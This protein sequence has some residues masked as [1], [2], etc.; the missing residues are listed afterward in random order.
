MLLGFLLFSNPG[1]SS[2]QQHNQPDMFLLTEYNKNHNVE[3]WV[4]SE[5]LD[6]IR[7]YWNGQQLLTR[8]GNV[9]YAPAWFIKGLP[10]FELD[11]ELWLARNKYAETQAIVLDQK[12]SKDWHKITYQIFEVPNQLGDLFRRLQVLEVYL[13][14]NPQPFLNVIQQHAIKS[15]SHVNARLKSIIKEG[16]EGLVI[17]NPSLVYETGRHKSMQKVK[18]KQDSECKVRGYTK[19]KGKYIGAVGALTCEI[20]E[21][22]RLRLFPALKKQNA[23]IKI[24]SGLS[25]L[26]RKQPPKIGTIVTFQYMGLTKNGLPRFPVFLRVRADKVAHEP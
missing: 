19:G 9:I 26:Q 24:G 11:G 7:A 1:V 25:D 5:K 17:R 21:S 20:L 18:L 6:G 13:Q 12:P 16:G 3:G 15:H 8:N 4:M 10:N 2:S 22:Q 14:Q 23:V